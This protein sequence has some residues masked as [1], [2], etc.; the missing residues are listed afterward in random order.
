[1]AI[2]DRYGLPVTTTS[3]VAAERFQEGMDRLLSFS[4]GA[5]A[6]FAAAVEADEGLALAHG[7]V[8]LGAVVQGGAS[9]ARA[10]TEK[11]RQTGTGATRGALQ[12]VQA[13]SAAFGGDTV[14]GRGLVADP[15]AEFP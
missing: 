13:P 10:A 5:E 1:M 14:R 11:A 4:A 3:A 2:T 12:H 9:T 15:V 7:G 8:V 6:C